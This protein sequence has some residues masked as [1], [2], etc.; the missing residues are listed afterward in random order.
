MEPLLQ[1]HRVNTEV[2]RDLLDRHSGLA[3]LSDANDVVTEL[4][5][6]GL[7][8]SNI[9]PGRPPGQARSDVT[10]SCS[11]PRAGQAAGYLAGLAEA[12]A[13]EL[14]KDSEADAKNATANAQLVFSTLSTVIGAGLGSVG[15]PVGTVAGSAAGKTAWSVVS[16]LTKPLV[17]VDPQAFTS[18]LDGDDMDENL[19]AAAIQ[20]AANAGL[21][22]ST[23]FD[24]T[25]THDPA[26]HEVTHYYWLVDN[27]DGTHSIDLTQAPPEYVSQQPHKHGEDNIPQQI[28]TWSNTIAASGNPDDTLAQISEQFSGRYDTG[29][30]NA[31]LARNPDK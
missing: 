26:G 29:W 13:R 16:T 7:G 14:S 1:R 31:L 18:T 25:G 30:D 27:G 19:W 8:H 11:S 17:A 23:D 28:T 10:Y 15:G 12:R 9:L 21:L 6:V 20:D 5:R 2:F 24:I 4:A 3:V 22:Q